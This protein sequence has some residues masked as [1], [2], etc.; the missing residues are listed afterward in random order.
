MLE[1]ARSKGFNLKRILTDNNISE[2]ILRNRKSR[3]TY[4]QLS[5]LSLYLID[6]LNDEY[7]GIVDRPLK[8]NT[9]KFMLHA[10]INEG[11]IGKALSVMSDFLNVMD[12][13]VICSLQKWETQTRFVMTRKT[14]NLIHN[15][16]VIEHLSLTI[17][18]ILCWMAK[19]QIPILATEL[20]YPKPCYSHEYKQL[21]CGSSIKFSCERSAISFSESSMRLENL[22]DYSQLKDFLRLLPLTL[23]TQTADANHLPAQIRGWLER[24]I[25]LHKTAPDIDAAAER[26]DLHPQALRRILKKEDT[27]Y[28]RIKME[29]RRDLAINKVLKN[30][31]SIEE[32]GHSLGFSEA[33]AFTR[34]FKQWTGLTPL[35]YRKSSRL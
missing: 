12:F 16:Y 30:E 17:H 8:P 6:L 34:A 23:L 10:A 4:E 5:C 7:F 13:G 29:T 32:V 9:G 14:G 26:F 11:T 22:R 1:G 20:D 3:V 19:V 2:D 25:N 33:C 28:Q 27:N 31:F 21:F 24:Q 15:N 35:H 18:R